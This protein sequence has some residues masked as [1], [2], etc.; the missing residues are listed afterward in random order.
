MADDPHISGVRPYLITGG[1][2]RP[3]DSTL[4][5]EAQVL[6]TWE[7]RAALDRLT[8]EHHDVVAMC[9]HPAAV[10]EIAA[11]LHLHLGVARVVVADLVALGYLL[12]RHPETATHQQVKIIERVISGLT[13]IR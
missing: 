10:A 13:A 8:Y 6:T 11:R 2:A 4:R 7:G 12:I 3:V 9:L 5:M 1:R